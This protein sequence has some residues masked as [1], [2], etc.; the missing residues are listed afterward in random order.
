MDKN[1]FNISKIET[2][3]NTLFDNKVSD[4]TFFSDLPPAIKQEWKDMVVVDIPSM[5]DLSGMG[6]SRINVFLYARPKSNGTKNVPVLSTMESKLRE[7][8]ANNT[9]V[10][11]QLSINNEWTDYDDQRDLHCNIYELILKIF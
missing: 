10:H 7:C 9:D 11:Y 4:N 5:Y 1:L 6:S 8:I 2:F 3:L